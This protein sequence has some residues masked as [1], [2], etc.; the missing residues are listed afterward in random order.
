MK[1]YKNDRS[2]VYLL[3]ITLGLYFLLLPA[4]V[5]IV[6]NWLNLNPFTIIRF[7]HFN[8]FAAARGIPLYQTFIYVLSLWVMVNILL[9]LILLGAGRLYAWFVKGS[10]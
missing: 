5:A 3:I 1:D 4:L 2:A 10:R 9:A 7:W 8:P 6:F